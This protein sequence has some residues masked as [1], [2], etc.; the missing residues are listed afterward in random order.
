MTIY[1]VI[2]TDPAKEQIYNFYS[3]IRNIFMNPLAADSFLDEYVK[4]IKRLSII[5]DGLPIC[6]DSDLAFF[7]YRIIHLKKYNFKLLYR[8]ADGV[9]IVDAA[10]HGLQELKLPF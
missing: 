2:I 9:V 7:D 8:I 1:K 5:A 10:Y 6:E 3:Y 4:T